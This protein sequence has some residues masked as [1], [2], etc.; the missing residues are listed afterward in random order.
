MLTFSG[1]TRFAFHHQA[2]SDQSFKRKARDP[3][4][5]DQLAARFSKPARQTLSGYLPYQWT[6]RESNPDDRH[7]I[8][9]SSRCTMSPLL[10]S[11]ALMG[12]EPI[13]QILQGLAASIGMRAQLQRSARELN[14]LHRLRRAAS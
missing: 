14:P 2:T 4:P 12:V 11:V 5:H 3:N 9:V 7:A 1:P 13:A 8:A 6:Y 10:L